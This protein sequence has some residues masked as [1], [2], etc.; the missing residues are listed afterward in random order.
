MNI[1]TKISILSLTSLMTSCVA[2]NAIQN[3]QQDK[4]LLEISGRVHVLEC[5]HIRATERA[6]VM[7]T[8]EGFEVS[9][10][11]VEM[12][13]RREKGLVSDVECVLFPAD[14]EWTSF[15]RIARKYDSWSLLHWK[16]AADLCRLGFP[17]SDSAVVALPAVPPGAYRFYVRYRLQDATG[18]RT[19]RLKLSDV[20]VGINGEVDASDLE[21]ESR[22]VRAVG[23][24]QDLL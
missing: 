17:A 14:T 3:Y 24:L 8:R 16:C 10:D 4:V 7:A 23:G 12:G 5:R 13:I 19:Y 20:E 22:E 6:Q 21:R 11:L 2:A 1:S 18:S 15:Q 9:V